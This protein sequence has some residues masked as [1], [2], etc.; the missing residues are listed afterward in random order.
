MNPILKI[1]H[2]VNRIRLMIDSSYYPDFLRQQGVCI[3]KDSVVLFPSYVDARLPYL[4]EIGNNVVISINVTILTHDATSAYA[5]DLI[6]VGPVTIHDHSF[7]GANT[8]ILCNVSIGPDSIVGAGSVVSK[9]VPPNTVYAGN[10]A[11]FVCSIDRFIKKHRE[12]GE[13]LPIFEGKHYE[14]PYIPEKKKGFLKESLRDTPGY[15]CARLPE[16][17]SIGKP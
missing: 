16:E 11:R 10:P 8:T 9:D 12:H 2:Y 3:G 7:I 1:K 5:G 6:K 13:T 17:R 4:L 15:F 14:H